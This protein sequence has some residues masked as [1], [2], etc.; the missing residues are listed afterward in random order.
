MLGWDKNSKT[1]FGVQGQSS[2]TKT[3]KDARFRRLTEA[4][5]EQKSRAIGLRLLKKPAQMK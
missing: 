4:E 5:A 3:G 1:S 2:G